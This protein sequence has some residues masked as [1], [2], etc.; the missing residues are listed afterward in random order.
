M[1]EI[2]ASGGSG[3]NAAP[4]CPDEQARRAAF[5]LYG[6]QP[7]ASAG[8]RLAPP[9]VL[10]WGPG[11]FGLGL[12][13]SAPVATLTA[14]VIF[15]YV[16]IAA[17][18]LLRLAAAFCA[19]RPAVRAPLAPEHLPSMSIIVALYQESEVVAGLCADLNRL[20]YPRDR[21]DVLLVLEAD[22]T[23]TLIAA[24]A[25]ARRNGFQVLVAPPCG[26][27]TK[28]R[29]LNFAL[30]AARGELVA[31]YDA[32]DAPRAD[33]LIAAAESFAANPQLGVVQA[34]LGWYN[35]GESWLTR[36]FALEYAAQFHGLLPLF[37]RLGAPLPL[38]GTSNV[39]RVE[40]LNDSGGWDPHNVTED[41]DL[42][43]RLARHGWQAGLIEPGTGEEAPTT[44]DAWTGQRSRWLKGHLVTWLVQMR[45][46]RQL[47]DTTGWQGVVAL[48]LSLCANVFSAL[49][50]L[51]GLVLI[52]LGLVLVLSG[53]GTLLT[54]TGLA[55]G[56]S[57]WLSAL[58]CMALCAHRAK[59][60]SR[61]F[62]L[63]TAPIYWLCQVPAVWRALKE[64]G[65]APYVWVKTRHGVS[66]TRREAP[67]DIANN[68]DADGADSVS[69]RLH[70]VAV[71]QAP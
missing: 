45:K 32:E 19:P 44:L 31:V 41:A 64:L 66:M 51:P 55:L 65:A 13:L 23:E 4:P 33:Q 12:G 16:Y 10:I 18:S 39:F 54:V 30:Q 9:I 46:P 38:G 50:Q 21:L 17:L 1:A 63:A 25:A 28:P 27:Q 67:D 2:R 70:R 68:L 49:A 52:A 5:G 58:I 48:Q 24:R 60:R 56:C 69:V 36:Q 22:D 42:G 8:R 26:P 71:R 3:L 61:L 14:L 15:T 34:P 7:L 40:A 47:L 11:S 53:H 6:S 37:A 35:S 43:F 59:V 57:A 20:Q 62:D 29:A